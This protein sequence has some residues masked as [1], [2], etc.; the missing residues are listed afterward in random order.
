MVDVL[1]L[2]L[3]T[4]T[5][6]ARGPVGGVPTSGAIRFGKGSASEA[7]VFFHTLKWVGEVLDPQPRPDVLMIEALLPPGAK[8]GATNRETRDRLAGLRG[9]VLAVAHGRGVYNVKEGTVGNIR[10]HFIGERMLKRA[11]AKPAIVAR[12]QELGWPCDD[13]NAGDALAAWS[14]ACSLIDPRQALLVS[15]LFNRRL[16][17]HA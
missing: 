14:Y 17:I 15:P 10:Q 7:A 2:D 4:I 5:G 6:W 9:V 11:K 8:V 1:A 13:D 12:C 16:R 3:A